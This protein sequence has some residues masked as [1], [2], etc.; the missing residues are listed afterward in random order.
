MTDAVK[1]AERPTDASVRVW[2]LPIRLFHWVLLIAIVVSVVAIELLD[3]TPLHVR[4]GQ[5]ILGLL[6]FRLVW[7]LVGTSSAQ[8][9]RF[10]RSPRTV[11]AYVRGDRVEYVGH[12]PLGAFSVVA[13]LA[14][15]VVQVASGLAADDEIFTTGP[16]AKH[17]GSDWV[18]R[19]NQIHEWN[20]WI[21][22]A[23]V[24]AHIAG[25]A[26][27]ARIKKLNLVAPMI[28]GRQSRT[29]MSPQGSQAATFRPVWM[30]WIVITLAAVSAWAVFKL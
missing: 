25:I 9:H 22:L 15:L 30:S 17:V 4:S 8:F 19:A 20:S 27:Y 5:V 7:G 21:L 10:L 26:W 18:S 11:L 23:L 14:C 29:P 12:N 28:T 6:V 3:D 1:N 16:L 24:I 2:D 13:M